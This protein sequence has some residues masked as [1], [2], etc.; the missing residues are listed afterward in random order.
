VLS[1]HALL[2]ESLGKA[3]NELQHFA[4]VFERLSDNRV[5][6]TPQILAR[7]FEYSVLSDRLEIANDMLVKL[8]QDYSESLSL[9]DPRF[10]LKFF[11]QSLKRDNIDG[12]AYLVNYNV[13]YGIDTSNYP[14]NNFRAALD[15]Y[16]NRKFDLNK[17]MIFLKFYQQHFA[18]RARREFDK[19][20]PAQ[21]ELSDST[22]LALSN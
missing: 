22:I 2:N 7:Y 1:C 19:V 14:I 12:V 13:R 9:V 3:N 16:L 4:F 20:E 17:V 5:K 21:Q 6:I 8:T 10:L 18:D 11:E 15:H